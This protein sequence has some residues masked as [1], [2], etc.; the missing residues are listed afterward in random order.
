MSTQLA[1][2]SHPPSTTTFTQTQTQTQAQALTHTDSTGPRAVEVV[3]TFGDAVVGVRHLTDPRGGVVRTATKALIAGGLA[4]LATSG[5]AFGYAANQAA[6]NNEALRAWK[7][8]GNPAWAF[9]PVAMPRGLDPLMIGGSI[10]GVAGLAYGLSRRKTERNPSHVRLG[11]AS[12]VDFA[13]EGVGSTFDLIAPLGD[14]F[15]VTPAPGAAP[16][17]VTPDTRMRIALG[18]T[19]F[20]IASVPA[21]KKQAAA[22]LGVD[23]R[24]V[25]FIAASALVHLGLL[26]LLRTVP[27]DQETAAGS[28][29]GNEL[30]SL[31]GETDSMM[32]P[33]VEPVITTGSNGTGIESEAARMALESGAMGSPEPK[34]DPGTR[35][36]KN[37]G[38]D[39]QVARNRELQ[40][41]KEAG[42]LGSAA[43]QSGDMFNSI[44]GDSDLTSGMD[45]ADIYGN[46]DGNGPGSGSDFGN[47]PS[48]RG[49]GGGGKDM[50]S[51]WVGGYNTVSRGDKSG[52]GYCVG[53]CDG[54]PDGR[55]HVVRAP[56]V[57]I[58]APTGCTGDAGCDP[59]IIR[60]YIK[61]NQSKIAYCYEKQLLAS[62]GLAGTVTAEFT[63][64]ANGTV[65]SARAHGVHDAV[66]SCVADVISNIKFPKFEGPFQVKYPFHLRPAG[67]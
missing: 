55:E 38:V 25:G 4:L 23:N 3:A 67:S 63:V 30:A 36:V 9:R 17:A 46:W 54:R 31:T 42:I 35:K 33:V 47:G 1:T 40:H 12:G 28:D 13:I 48:G 21:P 16:I 20:Q 27:S 18:S 32:D 65:M 56:T 49:P 22:T 43:F 5:V 34:P 50:G 2:H 66:S 44:G 58:G 61:R 39:P 14:G 6:E 19:V 59:E 62:P 37:D 45:D 11:T 52:D 26:A 24:V 29:S 57:K 53:K 51:V 41:A 60:R 8:A 64:N 7:A 10:L 15:V